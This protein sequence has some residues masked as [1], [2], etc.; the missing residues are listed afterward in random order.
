MVIINGEKISKTQLTDDVNAS[1]FR[2]MNKDQRSLLMRYNILAQGVFA[3]MNISILG[4]FSF[5]FISVINF[6]V[7]G[8]VAGAIATLF[9]LFLCWKTFK[10]WKAHKYFSNKAKNIWASDTD[11]FKVA[12]NLLENKTPKQTLSENVSVEDWAIAKKQQV[13]E[14]FKKEDDENGKKQKRTKSSAK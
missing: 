11:I 9:V 2:N 8:N 14:Q 12:E 7:F 6:H 10:Y 1:K 13:E 3:G 5:L 4:I